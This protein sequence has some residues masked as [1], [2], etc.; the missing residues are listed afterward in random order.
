MNNETSSNTSVQVRGLKVYPVKALGGIDLSE[1]TL[2]MTGFPYDR[3]WMVVD[4]K[5]VFVSQRTVPQM[6]RIAVALSEQQGCLSL[7]AEGLSSLEVEI[8]SNSTKPTRQVK[9]CD[10]TCL[11]I[12]E[13]PEAS[14]WLTEALGMTAGDTLHLVHF[15]NQYKRPV[16]ERFLGGKEA[17]TEFSDGYPYLLT[18]EE[19]LA[20][21]NDRLAAMNLAPVRMNRFRPNIVVS[22][23]EPFDEHTWKE[24]SFPS[25]AALELVKPC[26]RC[27]VI[28]VDQES[29]I[30]NPGRGEPLRTLSEFRMLEVPDGK[31]GELLRKAVFGENARMLKPGKIAVGGFAEVTV[32]RE[33]SSP[34]RG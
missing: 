31:T 8:C 24:L 12:D 6:A 1:A 4:N 10:D 7:S 21:L 9:V 28:T 2:T 33:P 22:G 23:L 17:F 13:G 3:H 15:P 34:I 16:E 29:G 18:T 14:R 20:A 11:G 19:S 25:G 27:P 26:G 32:G 5:G 30:R